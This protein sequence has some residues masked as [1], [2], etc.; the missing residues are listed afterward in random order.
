MVEPLFS[1]TPT[2]TE[3]WLVLCELSLSYPSVD[4]YTHMCWNWMLAYK[5]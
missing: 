2:S 1:S 5:V 4:V 3:V